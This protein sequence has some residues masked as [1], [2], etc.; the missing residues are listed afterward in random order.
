MEGPV[1]IIDTRE[2][3][4][5]TF[6]LPGLRRK[7]DAGDYSLEG[8]ENRVSVERKTLPDFI[9]TVIR[10]R[11]RFMKEL[12]KLSGYEAACVVVES[13][14]REILSGEF[15]SAAHPHALMGTIVSIIL[16]FGIPVYFCSDRQCAIQ[17]VEQYLTLFYRRK[18][19]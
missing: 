3:E 12:S 18:Q 9:H 2:K 13:E 16:D 15:R 17:F 4:P 11:K 7:L 5:Y 19:R 8:Y 1:I 14:L 6:S 10:G